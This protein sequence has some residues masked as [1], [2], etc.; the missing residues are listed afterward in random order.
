MQQKTKIMGKR[1]FNPFIGSEYQTGCKGKKVLI[2]GASHYCTYNASSGFH[3]P[4]WEECTS[5]KLRDS[6]K[7]NENCAYYKNKSEQVKLE[8]TTID[9]ITSFT[10]GDNDNVSYA[11]FFSFL[12][13]YFGITNIKILCNKLAFANYIQYFLPTTQTPPQTKNDVRNFEA[14][15]QTI[16]QLQPDIIIVWGVQVTNHFSR[17]YINKMVQKLEKQLDDYFWDL[18][19]NGHK[20]T[21]IN[22]YHPCND[23]WWS[24]NLK[25]F[26]KALDKVFSC[27]QI[28]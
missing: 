20:C 24:N 16:E 4:Y 25:C 27:K 14:L 11:N 17:K 13:E 23:Y 15:L 18:E 10:D 6:S 12:G 26:K 21:I 22:P 2:L 8:D 3:C 9:E 5:R 7:F 1:F 19:Y 28:K